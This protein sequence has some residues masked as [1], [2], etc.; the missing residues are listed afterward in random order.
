[1]DN[2][3]LNLFIN[4]NL[5][6]SIDE[7]YNPYVLPNLAVLPVMHRCSRDVEHMQLLRERKNNQPTKLL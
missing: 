2:I 1:L 4:L 5:Q 6:L 7:V 3:A